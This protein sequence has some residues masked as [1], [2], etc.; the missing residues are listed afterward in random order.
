MM[1]IILTIIG[2]I[3][4]HIIMEQ[5]YIRVTGGGILD[6]GVGMQA[7]TVVGVGMQDGI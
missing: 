1:I 2:M 4:T 5:V 7:G 6:L 3:M